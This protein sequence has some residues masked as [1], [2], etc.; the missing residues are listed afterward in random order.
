MPDTTDHAYL[1]LISIAQSRNEQ[2]FANEWCADSRQRAIQ[3]LGSQD[4]PHE[5]EGHQAQDV[6]MLPDLLSKNF[7]GREEVLEQIR[8]SFR[9]NAR[10]KTLRCALWGTLGVG[11]SQIALRFAEQ[12]QDQYTYVFHVRAK[13]SADIIEDYRKI[14]RRLKIWRPDQELSEGPAIIELLHTW[15]REHNR[16]LMIFDDALEPGTARAYAPL[17]GNGHILFTTRSQVT[18]EA[19]V[20]RNSVYGILPLP[21]RDAIELGLKLQNFDDTYLMEKEVAERLAEIVGCLPI[22]IEQAVSLARLR[23]ISLSDVLPEV[24]RKRSLLKQSH[25]HSMHEDGLSTGAILALTLDTLKTG[26]P[27][28][29]ALFHLLVFLSP[30]SIPKSLFT[31]GTFELKQHFIRQQTYV[32]GLRRTR[33]ELF[34][35]RFKAVM[36]RGPIYCQNPSEADFWRPWMPFMKKL[37]P[38]TLP[39]I[40]S[41]HDK[42]VEQ[43]FHGSTP[44]QAVLEDEL[45]REKAYLQLLHAGLVRY[46]DVKTIWIHDLF[47][48][49]TKTLLEVQSPVTHQATAY[50]VLLML[51]FQ[52]PY[53]SG[54]RDIPVCYKYLPHAVSILDYCKPFYRGL[55]MWPELAHLTASTFTTR[56]KGLV[57]EKD[58]SAMEKALEY[59]KLA[60]SGYHHA[61]RRLLDHPLVTQ[62]EVILHARAEYEEESKKQQSS[63]HNMCF[64]EC[65]RFGS[66]AA[67]AVQTCLKIGALIL[68]LAGQFP[69]A[70]KWTE[71]A[72]Q[73]VYSLYGKD[74]DEVWE[75]RLKLLGLYRRAGL[76]TFGEVLGNAMTSALPERPEGVLSKSGICIASACG[77]S[78]MGIGRIDKAAEWYNITRQL[79]IRIYGYD[80][81]L[82]L[83]ALLKLAAAEGERCAHG[84][85]RRWAQK[86]LNIHEEFCHNRPDWYCPL[87]NRLIHFE[88]L[89]ALQLFQ[90]GNLKEAMD[91]CKR[92]LE[93][94]RWEP[95]MDRKDY[96]NYRP[97]WDSGLQ[98]IWIWGCIEFG[99]CDEPL[100]WE[101]PLLRITKELSREAVEKFGR[102]REP[103]C[104][105]EYGSEGMCRIGDMM[106]DLDTTFAELDV[107]LEENTDDIHDEVTTDETTVA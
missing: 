37:A 66:P 6:R 58:G 14:A 50:L 29:D 7:T 36:A 42:F 84:S 65:Y 68:P 97:V 21:T 9:S 49:L 87:P 40:D 71:K 39:R 5:P 52:F 89:I 106:A 64:T 80:T 15:L 4:T 74:H 16:W 102:L 78:A 95:E 99:E 101:V 93:N 44:L 31:Q 67:R 104:G 63:L 24:E 47:A 12:Y 19:L 17:E 35:L 62:R 81:P 79:W 33:S 69:E 1:T 100:P 25:P 70:V 43:F 61:W 30:S 98:A 91:R 88:V 41:A 75:T 51:Y 92:A 86:G 11:K 3:G 48:D 59:Y 22:A 54:P 8:R 82:Q 73:C 56:I 96:T 83:N 34:N 85:S 105:T 107:P 57:L 53:P 76:N 38:N 20:D 18:A 32:Q 45:L 103:C 94:C 2:T 26:S 23:Q 77:D 46:P 90:L 27:H 13:R 28:A 55:T 60:F 10:G 72:M